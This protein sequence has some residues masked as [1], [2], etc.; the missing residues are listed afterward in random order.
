MGSVKLDTRTV[1]AP[2]ATPQYTTPDQ[3]VDY[4]AG[5]WWF[6]NASDQQVTVQ[7]QSAWDP[8]ATADADF[9]DHGSSFTVA[10]TTGHEVYT[11]TDVVGAFRFKVT[12]GSTATGDLTVKGRV[13][14]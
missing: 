3:L 6:K 11:L 5:S 14:V 12:A 8:A 9:A 4:V 1:S 13:R 2:S 7:P 10:A